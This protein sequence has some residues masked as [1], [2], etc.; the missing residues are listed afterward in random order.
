MIIDLTSLNPKGTLLW[1]L[2]RSATGGERENYHVLGE[3][4]IVLR[5]REQTP[6]AAYAPTSVVVLLRSPSGP[7]T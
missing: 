5:W 2:T 3:R 1:R 6:F 4:R 7:S